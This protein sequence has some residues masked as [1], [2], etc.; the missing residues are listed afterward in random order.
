MADGGHANHN[1]QGKA[2]LLVML[3]DDSAVVRGLITR[4]LE[5][6]PR[7]KV[8]NSVQN[9]QMAVDSVQR[10]RP[11]IIIL[12]I[13]MPVMDGITALPK[14]LEQY[15]K[16][17]VI[18]CS[19]LTE[20][21]ASVS[22]KAMSLGA[23]EYICKPSSTRDAGSG[24]DFQERLLKLVRTIGRLET[25]VPASM[26]ERPEKIS[27]APAPKTVKEITLR[28]NVGAWT[29]KPDC[30]AI[31]SSTGGPKA[32]FEVITHFKNFPVP[33]AL[34]QHMPATFTKILAQHI[35]TQTGVNAVEA[36]NGA[37]LLPGQVHVAP[38]GYHMEFETKESGVVT[39]ITNGPPENFCK[40]SV[41]P[42]LRSLLQIYGKKILC[43]ILTGM[44]QD[45]FAGASQIVEAGCRVVAQDEETSVVWGMPGAVALGG[46]CSAVLPLDQ[47]GPY[48]RKA[49]MTG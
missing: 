40:P 18:M 38:G 20:K 48:V 44:G 37:P 27:A 26:R 22:M 32:L 7:I 49:V 29:G 23:T 3:V 4:A 19:T 46:L 8:V 13:E 34:T 45:G 10:V 2:E 21:G 17:K 24:S 11:D 12:D 28:S 41:D 39:K 16:T 25:A 5:Q 14:I 9:G 35:Q 30:I 31:G 43:V 36:E 33:I 1:N 47:I 42:M 6:D 15:P